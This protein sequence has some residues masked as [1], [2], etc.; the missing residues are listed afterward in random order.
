LDGFTRIRCIFNTP[1]AF[2]FPLALFHATPG[3]TAAR[4]PQA[5]TQEFCQHVGITRDIDIYIDIRRLTQIGNAAEKIAKPEGL[6]ISFY[7]RP[8]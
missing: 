3:V 8:P 5:P 7:N 6:S 2:Q 1:D 4:S